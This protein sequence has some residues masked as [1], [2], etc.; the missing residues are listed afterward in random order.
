MYRCNDAVMVFLFLFD[1]FGSLQASSNA[2]ETK[3]QTLPHPIVGRAVRVEDV[4]QRLRLRARQQD[5]P[6]EVRTD[7]TTHLV[8]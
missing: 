3:T 5:V 8:R 1:I 7:L 2:A 4:E 6:G